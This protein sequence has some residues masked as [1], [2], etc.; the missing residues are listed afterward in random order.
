MPDHEGN[1][2]RAEKTVKRNVSVRLI[3]KPAQGGRIP[4]VGR[5]DSGRGGEACRGRTIQAEMP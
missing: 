2:V 5:D 3:S 4:G 1:P